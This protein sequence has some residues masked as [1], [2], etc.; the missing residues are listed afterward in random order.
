MSPRL[1]LPSALP[2][3][4]PYIVPVLTLSL[5][6]SPF[7]WH[8]L[9]PPL[10][11]WIVIP[12]LDFLIL[13][14][15]PPPRLT[16]EQRKTLQ[17]MSSFKLAVYLWCPTQLALLIWGAYRIQHYTH[18]VRGLRLIA[19]LW[20]LGLVA[21]EGINCSHEL[22][23]RNSRLERCLGK[24]LLA[25]VMYAHFAIEHARGHHANVA[26]PHDPATMR[27]GES[28]YRFLP[29][30]ILGGYRSAWRL[31]TDRLS[32]HVLPFWAPHN[33][34][35]VFTLVQ[36]LFCVTF[37]FALGPRALALFLFQAVFAVVLLEQINAIEHYGLLRERSP[38]GQYERV[39][40][41]HSWDAPHVVSSYLL[42]KLQVHAD[43]HLRTLSSFLVRNT[44][45]LLALLEFIRLAVAN[46]LSSV[47]A[48]DMCSFR[49]LRPRRRFTSVSDARID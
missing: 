20:S 42:F 27:Y 3:F 36:C 8:A 6:Y 19:L 30:T 16:Y 44:R 24:L 14:T 37:Y 1:S 47:C 39:G 2:F 41:R 9:I 38:C 46:R 11:V 35:L 32:R 43:H 4:L 21:A 22:L 10:F 18:P 40:P 29:R 33:E 34:M 15:T 12:L 5:H 25:S 7:A 26:T 45:V 13:P 17:S 23:H 49:A 31:E 28:F 48:A